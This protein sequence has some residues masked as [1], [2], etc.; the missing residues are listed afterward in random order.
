MQ[1]TVSTEV[2]TFSFQLPSQESPKRTHR[3]TGSCTLASF[4]KVVDTETLL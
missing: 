1:A 3:Q 4:Q 2:V